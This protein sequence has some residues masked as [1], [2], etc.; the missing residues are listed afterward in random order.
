MGRLWAVAGVSV[1]FVGLPALAADLCAL[2]DIHGAYGFQFEGVTK[3]GGPE[4][5]L[6]GVARLVF[7]GTKEVS[8]VS[9]VNFNGLF[10]GNPVTGS[11]EFHTDCS[12][13]VHLQDTSGAFQNLTGRAASGGNRVEMR[14]SDSG[15]AVHGLMVRIAS[16]CAASGLSGRFNLALT[17]HPTPFVTEASKGSGPA[18]ATWMPMAQAT[19]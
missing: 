12:L 3:I 11:Y 2:S 5:P 10:L 15:T 4:K 17:G 9:S 6:A 1:L 8:G 14:Q 19:W 7:D 18:K 13:D 16:V